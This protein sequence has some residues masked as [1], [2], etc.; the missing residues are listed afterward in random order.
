MAEEKFDVIIVGA[1]PAGSAAALVCARAGLQTVVFERGEFPGAKNIFGGILYTPILNELI[2][3]F[4]E[5]A[6]LERSVI[7]RRF[8]ILSD[9][10][11]SAFS[12]KENRFNHP[13]FNHSFTALRSRF[14][15]W[16]AKKAEEAGAMVI[17]Q[18]LVEEIWV[19]D[20]KVVGVRAGREGGDLRA[21][22][23][24]CAEG[25][26]S[27]LSEKLGLRK[28]YPPKTIAVAVKELMAL[29]KET[30]NDR[31]QLEEGEGAAYEFFGGAVNGL[32]G[33][34]FIYTNK[35]SLSVGLGCTIESLI[36]QK[37]NANA[38]LDRFK[39]HPVIRPLIKGAE[40]QEFA[41]HLIPEGGYHQIP[42]MVMDGLMLAG[43]AAH[44]V[45]SSLYHEGTNLAMASG[46]LAGQTA[47]EAKE[48]GD[49]SGSFLN[50]YIDKLEQSFV[51]K[52]LKRYAGIA[53][54]AHSSPEFFK[55]YPDLALDLLKDYFTISTDSKGDIQKK[56]WQKIKEKTSL[57]KL[58]KNLFK[59]KKVMFPSA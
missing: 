35:D 8:S 39:N 58:A 54:W 3:K 16:F 34:A 5:E 9:S 44:L 55:E 21:D 47:V 11:E 10:A 14:D 53:R 40:T 38:L 49:F 28:K 51:M 1:G 25:A 19:E 29:P 17:P 26:N 48:K 4:W 22:L 24:I 59:F 2:P 32:I 41:A 20:G 50:R 13:P 12:F 36:D 45:N 7:S 42:K 15:R 46:M 43:D 56:M 6:P 52:D 31:F 30:I 27:F 33:S 37:M 23:V 18:T 57:F